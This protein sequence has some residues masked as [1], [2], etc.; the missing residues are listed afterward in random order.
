MVRPR[1]SK[2]WLDRKF[3]LCQV[4]SFDSISRKGEVSFLFPAGLNGGVAV[5]TASDQKRSMEPFADWE[6]FAEHDF[7]GA[8]R[9]CWEMKWNKI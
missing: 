7:D 2:C 8:E 3:N 5:Y 1:E 6:V 9:R 4:L